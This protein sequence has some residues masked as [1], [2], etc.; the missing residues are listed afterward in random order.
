MRFEWKNPFTGKSQ[1]ETFEE[2][3]FG[4]STR[5]P[6]KAPKHADDE[7]LYDEELDE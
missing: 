7:E 2:V 4:T 5:K 6:T 3:F 1:H